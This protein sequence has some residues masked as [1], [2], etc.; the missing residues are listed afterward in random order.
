MLPAY[1]PDSHFVHC[2]CRRNKSKY[3]TYLPEELYS[4]AV[5]SSIFRVTEEGRGRGGG[6]WFENKFGNAER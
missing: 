5:F 4:F 1:L 2:K 6:F 3:C